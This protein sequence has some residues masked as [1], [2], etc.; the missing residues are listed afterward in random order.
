MINLKSAFKNFG[1][2][3]FLVISS[4]IYVL[5]MLIWTASTR[6]SVESKAMSIKENHSN[7]INFINNEIK[8]CT[9]RPQSKTIWGEACNEA[10]KSKI[11]VDYIIKNI[12]LNNPY[13]N[14]DLLIQSAS[15]PRIQ[16]EGKAGQ[17]TKKGII[18]I[19]L[20]DFES[21][22]GSEWIVGTCVK[23]PCVA[24]GNNELT[25]IYR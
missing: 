17:S 2:L 25:S 20:S 12:K 15:D 9:D 8:N 21:E 19:S 5:S 1:V 23:S 16:A 10:W 6:A 14:N 4:I 18:F 7:V 3:D 11:I 22:P 24:A 13:N